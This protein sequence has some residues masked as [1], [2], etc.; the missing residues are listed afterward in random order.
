MSHHHDHALPQPP[1]PIRMPTSARNVAVLLVLLG[2]GTLA[3]AFQAGR[4]ELAWSSYLIG[5]YYTL[6][7]GVF[8]ALWISVQHLGRGV[9][10][11]TMRRVPEAMTSW[12]FPGGLLALAVG[13]GAPYLYHWSHVE[14]VAQDE[15]LQHKSPFLNTTMFYVLMSVCLGAWVLLARAITGN[16]RRQDQEGGI[17]LTRRNGVLSAVFVIVFALS[18]S[19]VGFYLLM[20]LEP[21]WF[22]TMFAVLLFTDALQTGTAFVALVVGYLILRGDFSGFVTRNHLHSLGKMVFATTGFWAYIALCQFLLIWYANIP[23]ETVYYIRRW[24]NGWQPYLLLL[25]VVKFLVP[26]IFMVPRCCKREPQPLMMASAWLLFAQL[27]ELYMMVAPAVGHGESAAHGHLP[28]VE[29]TVGVGFL[30]AFYL[31]FA[32]CLGRHGAVPLKDPALQESLEY[33]PA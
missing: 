14:A 24:E 27:W 10:S 26:F 32:Y 1:A 30:A 12:L 8:G 29:F 17:E 20:S 19:V 6:A 15:L 3:W 22:S 16:S 28:C 2:L 25:P 18:I 11:V 4:P 9:W 33:H 7:L 13:L 23:E 5:A 31:L 21:H